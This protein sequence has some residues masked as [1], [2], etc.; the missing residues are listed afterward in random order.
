MNYK[1]LVIEGNIGAGKTSLANKLAEET[2]SRLILER[3]WFVANLAPAAN[4][5]AIATYS[6]SLSAQRNYF[7]GN[8]S[9]LEGSALYLTGAAT[10][11]ESAADGGDDD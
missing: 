3:A 11:N 8:E 5:G 4:G 6:T 2:G 7:F 9:D 10:P 1:Y